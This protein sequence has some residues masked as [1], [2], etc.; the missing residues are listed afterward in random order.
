[1]KFKCA[2]I[3]LVDGVEHLEGFCVFPR[4]RSLQIR[5]QLWLVQ[6]LL[7]SPT[8]YALWQVDLSISSLGQKW[9]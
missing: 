1:M 2:V 6:A 3:R 9:P 8:M 7:V 4:L 5:K